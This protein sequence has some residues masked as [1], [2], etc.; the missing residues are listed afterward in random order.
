MKIPA[1][2]LKNQV[3]SNSAEAHALHKKSK[4]GES[5]GQ[6]ILFSPYEAF[7]L[8]EQNKIQIEDFR[9]NL[10]SKDDLLKKFT[11]LSKNFETNYPAFKD[12]REKSYIVKTALKFGAEFRVYEKNSRHSKWI[13]VPVREN[14]FLKW[15]NFAAKNR[16]AHSSHKNLLIAIVDDENCVTYYEIKWIKP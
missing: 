12:L 15:Q 7:Y 16:V 9:G 5:L 6:K 8:T 10:L 11:N 4:F 1:T 2:L 13:C 3:T 14:S